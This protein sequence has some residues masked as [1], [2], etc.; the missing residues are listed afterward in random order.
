MQV[1]APR[2]FGWCLA[3]LLYA[4]I[5]CRASLDEPEWLDAAAAPAVKS[6][7]APARDLP[8]APAPQPDAA[9]PVTTP[10]PDAARPPDTRD[11][12]PM[13]AACPAVP[14]GTVV[15]CGS[16]P[17]T[18]QPSQKGSLEIR[19]PGAARAQYVCATS[20]AP[21]TGYMFDDQDTMRA[22]PAECC[23]AVVTP[24][25][26][27]A[28]GTGPTYLGVPHGPKQIKPQELTNTR[29]GRLRSNPFGLLVRDAAGGQAVAMARASWV[30]WAGD[31]LP[32]MA[33][34]GSGPYYFPRPVTINYVVVP[35]A[36]GSPVV[37]VAPEVGTAADVKDL[38]GHP[39]MA[40]CAGVGGA[41]LSFIAGEIAGTTLSNNSGRFGFDPTV[42]PEALTNAAKL[43]SDYGIPITATEYR[44]KMK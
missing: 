36:K 10:P 38:L 6:D 4:N 34:D 21:L 17:G 15:P 29:D 32:H 2:R 33:P 3:G 20:W 41:P 40:A 30:T 23:R 16:D 42:T 22:D 27:P 44:T 31:G 7:A 26:P 14:T 8:P 1:C 12:A 19:Y 13:A 24:G 43:L 18:G 39:T 5:G 37:V 35:D 9:A 11:A 25:V 28:P